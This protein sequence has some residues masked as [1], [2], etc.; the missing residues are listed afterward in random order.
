MVILF[1]RRTDNIT[2]RRSAPESVVAVLPHLTVRRFHLPQTVEVIP[3]VA[4]FLWPE[5]AFLFGAF[6]HPP[7][8][9][10]FVAAVSRLRHTFV[11]VIML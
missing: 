10:V 7:A 3:A 5:A 11:A 2:L 1:P 6:Y 4:P 8:G 9:V